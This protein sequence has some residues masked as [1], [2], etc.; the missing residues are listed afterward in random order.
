M[1]IRKGAG[2]CRGSSGGGACWGREEWSGVIDGR[3]GTWGEGEELLGVG[4][5]NSNLEL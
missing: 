3:T 5:E 1:Q 2:V 4:G